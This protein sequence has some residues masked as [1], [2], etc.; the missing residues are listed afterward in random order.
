MNCHG[1]A[2]V[3]VEVFR[4]LARIPRADRGEVCSEEQEIKNVAHFHDRIIHSRAAIK[5]SDLMKIT[6]NGL[7]KLHSLLRLFGQSF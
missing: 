4:D 6:K 7:G 5:E 3:V 2:V 1:V